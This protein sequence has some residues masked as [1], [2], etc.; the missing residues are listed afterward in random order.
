[1]IAGFDDKI[2]GGERGTGG[3]CLK[4]IRIARE[5]I[6]YVAFFL[7]L[8]VAFYLWKPSWSG[9]PLGLALFSAFFFRNPDRHIPDQPGIVVSPADGVILDISETFEPEYIKDKALRVS[10]FLSLF[11]VH[12]N[13]I[14]VDGEVE[15][16]SRVSG[17]F[18]PAFHRDASRLNSRNLVGMRTEW[19]KLLV[20][21]ITGYV[22]RRIVCHARIGERYRTG[23]VFGLI[24]F[25]SCTEVYLPL[26]VE[27]C[28]RVGEK[29]RG[30]ESII[31]RFAT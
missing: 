23:D 10:I 14:P 31:G 16:I 19:G 25:G 22:A 6:P 2:Y 9:L 20:V 26:D 27:L 17:K 12:I 29:V 3:Y 13:R 7:L 18:V 30:G 5:G 1:L 11:N 28:V 15:Y 24:K 4:K 21:Q 8:A